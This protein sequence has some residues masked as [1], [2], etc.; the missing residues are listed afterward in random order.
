M[1]GLG[2]DFVVINNLDKKIKITKEQAIFLCDRNFGIGADQILILEPSEKAD[3]FMR[4]LNSDGS[5]V[6]MCGNG[7]RAIAVFAQDQGV[8][9][10]NI[11][12]IETLASI[13][14]AEIVKENFVQIDMGGAYF[15]DIADFPDDFIDREIEII[16]KKLKITC[17]S[18]GNPHAV[19]F[20]D[21]LDEFPIKKYGSMIENLSIF[22]NRINT[23]FVEIVSNKEIKMRVWER[24]AGETLACGTGATAS[25][26]GAIKN[27]HVLSN[28]WII[29]HLKGG[30]LKI[31][32]DK[33]K[34]S[35]KML[36]EAKIV[37]SGE[38]D[39]TKRAN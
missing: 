34:N 1:Q 15:R 8:K 35:F 23:E 37:F 39:L 31:Y 6:E 2:N 9:K 36:G 24:G 29:V 14:K 10:E 32:W 20:V 13:K 33:N 5:E 7:A 30:D 3:Y 11:H 25:V 21:N 26:A 19:I 17:V 22:P 12:S 16:D 28:E 38:I 18:V 27:N 4:I